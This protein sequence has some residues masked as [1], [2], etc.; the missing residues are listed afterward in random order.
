M[1]DTSNKVTPERLA[2]NVKNIRNSLDVLIKNRHL[3]MA[4]DVSM[5]KD[6]A[7]ILE[8]MLKK[9]GLKRISNL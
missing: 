6:K 8:S 9:H 4:E 1:N 5:L 2:Q 7:T 3:L